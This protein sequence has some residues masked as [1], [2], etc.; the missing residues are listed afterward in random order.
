VFIQCAKIFVLYQIL[1]PVEVNHVLSHIIR[2]DSGTWLR[3]GSIW[4]VEL[5]F[6]MTK[7]FY[8]FSCRLQMSYV[9]ALITITSPLNH[10]PFITSR[11]LELPNTSYLKGYKFNTA[12]LTNPRIEYKLHTFMVFFLKCILFVLISVL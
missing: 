12:L 2:A 7:Y 3:P 10:S 1:R 4:Q 6:F 11:N 9:R 8:A 5:N